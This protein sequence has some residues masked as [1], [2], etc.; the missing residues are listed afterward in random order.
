MWLH[1]ASSSL[2][3]KIN[4]SYTGLSLSDMKAKA[5]S[6]S[7]TCVQLFDDP[8]DEIDLTDKL[9]KYLD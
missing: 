6:R 9:A 2:I 8:Y 7:L 4:V 5:L 1:E 3:G